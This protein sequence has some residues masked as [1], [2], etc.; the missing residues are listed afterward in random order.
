[1]A[2]NGSFVRREGKDKK[3]GEIKAESCLRN[4]LGDL[5]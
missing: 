4:A 2:E 3:E 1:M 5:T